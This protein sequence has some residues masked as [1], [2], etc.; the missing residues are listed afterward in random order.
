MAYALGIQQ[1]IKWLQKWAK[2]DYAF[3]ALRIHF[4]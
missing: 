2:L 3:L 1:N 4:S